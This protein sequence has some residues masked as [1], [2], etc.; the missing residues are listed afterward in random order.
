MEILVFGRSV[1]TIILLVNHSIMKVTSIIEGGVVGRCDGSEW[2]KN[3]DCFKNIDTF[4]GNIY[5]LFINIK[6]DYQGN[7]EIL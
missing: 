5:G 7:R 3:I 1:I 2:V 6:G 4:L